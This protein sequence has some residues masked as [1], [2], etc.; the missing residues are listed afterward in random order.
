MNGT[1][2]LFSKQYAFIGDLINGVNA[3]KPV[4]AE[5]GSDVMPS[6]WLHFGYNTLAIRGPGVPDSHAF[7]TCYDLRTF[8][9]EPGWGQLNPLLTL[10]MEFTITHSF[11]CMT[12]F[13]AN[14]AID[15]HVNKLQ[16]PGDKPNHQVKQLH[17]AQ[18]YVNSGQ[19][20]FGDYHGAPVISA[21]TPKH[22]LPNC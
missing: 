2:M 4:A 8:P 6:S 1:K 13:E 21:A 16:S 10:P 7:A 22:A 12:G 17:D 15:K 11:N 19:L 20:S 14:P 18:G 5:A 9:G 3:G